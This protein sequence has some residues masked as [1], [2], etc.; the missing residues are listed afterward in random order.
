MAHLQQQQ[1]VRRS[2]FTMSSVAFGLMLMI[3]FGC[4]QRV[5]GNSGIGANETY[6]TVGEPTNTNEGF[7]DFLFGDDN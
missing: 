6:P 2:I 7:G 1:T 3:S 5:V 4:E